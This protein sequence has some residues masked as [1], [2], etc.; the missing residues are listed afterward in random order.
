VNS[1]RRSGAVDARLRMKDLCNETGL[2]RQA[3][4]FYIQAGLLPEGAK[5]GRNMAWYGTA[6]VER[7]RLIRELQEERLLPLK[8][9]RALL[10]GDTEALPEAQRNLLAE[11]SSQLP[12][13]VVTAPTR[14]LSVSDALTRYDVTTV[15]LER[16]IE[17][18]LLTVA[19]AGAQREL[20]GDAA[21]LLDL[22]SQFRA[23]G[24]SPDR[25]FVVDDLVPF[26]TA[27]QD[28]VAHETQLL[29]SRLAHLPPAEVAPMIERALPLVQ[30][31]LVHFHAAAV[32]AVFAAGLAA[33]STANP[34]E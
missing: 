33:R 10:A 30:A 29:L 13:S 14:C 11:V 25:G 1:A 3:I 5:T 20:G 28:L 12:A 9:I 22:W 8:T 26:V 16:M 6:H 2:S 24:F 4:H 18:G 7:L 34:S 32:R 27:V 21:R 31:S 19:G 23:L 15:E 17:L